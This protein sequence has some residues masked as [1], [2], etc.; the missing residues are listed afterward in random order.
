MQRRTVSLLFLGLALVS[1]RALGQEAATRSNDSGRGT[2]RLLDGS[3][4]PALGAF[5]GEIQQRL[6]PV[7]D[8][9][10]EESGYAYATSFG[11]NLRPSGGVIQRWLAPLGLP[12]GAIIEEIRL[13]VEDADDTLNITSRLTFAT[14]ATDGSDACDFV[15]VLTFW[16]S[17]SEGIDGRGVMVMQDDE[18][19][20]V[21]NQATGYP[22]GCPSEN[23]L[24]FSILVELYPPDH[25]FSGAVVRW[26]RS[27][28]PAPPE[29]TFN[30]VPTSHPFF[31]F[32]E[33]LAISGI[34]AGCGTGIYCPDNPVTR[35]QMAVF[36]AKALGLHWPL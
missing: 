33:A 17:T 16:T 30:D 28:S 29:A 5:G 27:V 14:E 36:L 2:L 7:T 10:P 20:V 9:V 31:Q 22:P 8:F 4:P 24:W 6:I 18:P 21:L 35:G 13:L 34:T 1:S 32:I 26:R 25:V 15:W 3:P 11:S 19:Y 23:Y 12:S